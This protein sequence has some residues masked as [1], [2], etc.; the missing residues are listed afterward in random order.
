MQAVELV[1]D[2]NVDFADAYLALQ[3]AE[4]DETV[5]TFDESDFRRL[6]VD[7]TMPE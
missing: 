6:P 4:H 7:W 3:A 5:C 1:R 2:R